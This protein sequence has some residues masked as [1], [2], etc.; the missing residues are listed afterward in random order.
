[1]SHGA[2]DRAGRS[3]GF[4]KKEE[5]HTRLRSQDDGMPEGL[6]EVRTRASSLRE[7]GWRWEMQGRA[8]AYREAAAQVRRWLM[9]EG[10][11]PQRAMV[12]FVADL[13]E[14]SAE[15]YETHD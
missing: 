5:S 11:P 8:H 14:R 2:S 6:G 7:H 4:R 3:K 13:L 10:E 9:K 1:V 15:V 12:E